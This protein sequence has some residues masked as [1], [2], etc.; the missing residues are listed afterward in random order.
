M[1]T[2]MCV[3]MQSISTNQ[4][5]LFLSTVVAGQ[6]SSDRLCHAGSVIFTFVDASGV[7]GNS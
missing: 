3:L 6:V 7:V 5:T 4:E 1:S 2:S